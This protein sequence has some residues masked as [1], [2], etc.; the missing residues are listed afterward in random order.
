[1]KV[2]IIKQIPDS[3]YFRMSDIAPHIDESGDV[4]VF[5]GRGTR[6]SW[7]APQVSTTIVVDDCDLLA[8]HVGFSHK[9]RGGQGWHY[10]TT[11][12]ETTTK[13]TWSQLPDETRQRIFDNESKAPTWAKRPGKFK[14]QAAK[15][16]TK[17]QTTYKLVR[18][19]D[20]QLVSLYDNDTEYTIGKRLAQ[21]AE[22]DHRGGWYSHPSIDQVKSLLASGNLVPDRCID[23]GMDLVM[24]R[25]EVSGTIV[26]Y[27]N[28]KIA[29]T[30]LVPVEIIEKLSY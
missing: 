25:C 24:F 20:G 14:S 26:K 23:S 1:M 2:K 9:H 17:T 30:Y 22:A 15:P 27:P 16:S 11:D 3:T 7:G 18:S 13:I 8:L 21:K 10:F 19:V 4:V 6:R 12:G 5:D 28:G 29:S